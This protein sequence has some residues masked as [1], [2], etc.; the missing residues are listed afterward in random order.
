MPLGGLGVVERI[1]MLNAFD[2]RLLMLLT[3]VEYGQPAAEVVRAASIT[4]SNWLG[5]RP[6][7]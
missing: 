6:S 4:W 1:S 7:P 3:T 5:S 2:Q